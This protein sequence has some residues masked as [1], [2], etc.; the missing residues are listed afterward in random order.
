MLSASYQTVNLQDIRV[1]PHAEEFPDVIGVIQIARIG[2]SY[3]RDRRDDPIDPK[4]G[5]YNTT[6]FQVAGT[7]LG[8]EV[9]FVKLLNQSSYYRPL[10]KAVFASSLRVGWNEPYGVSNELPITERY[11]AGGSTTLRGLNLDEAG[12]DGGGD[13]M[14]I[15]NLEYR[16]PIIEKRI[17][18]LV[19]AFFYD[20]GNVFARISDV[21]LQDFTHTVGTGLRYK[22][23]VGPVRLDFGLNL[24]PEID[25]AGDMEKRFHVFF[26]LGHAF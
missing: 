3:I 2:A 26:T 10:N 20:T 21:R 24:H 13:A 4:K 17:K 1:N 7:A 6:T 25:S 11:F 8:S 14:V 18:N 12:P 5:T 15:G 19:A 22:T 9:N 23:P 16:F